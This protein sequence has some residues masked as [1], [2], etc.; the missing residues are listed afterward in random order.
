MTKV[1]FDL[2]FDFRQKYSTSHAL[3]Y[4]S[5]KIREQLDNG[6]FAFV[7]FVDIQ[8]AFDTADHEIFIQKLSH[9]IIR[10]VAYNCFL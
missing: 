6:S 4:L 9:Y 8:K 5:D 10:G 3:F 2:Q 7:I 1:A